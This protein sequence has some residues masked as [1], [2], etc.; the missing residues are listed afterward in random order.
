MEI[1]LTEL[2]TVKRSVMGAS[3]PL[4]H[5]YTAPAA[6][7]VLQTSIFFEGGGRG[8]TL[9]PV[10]MLTNSTSFLIMIVGYRFK[11]LYLLRPSKSTTLIGRKGNFHKSHVP[12]FVP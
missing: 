1:V 7:I 12:L 4:V 3:H 9:T 2:V 6:V 5:G 8:A 11:R 10:F